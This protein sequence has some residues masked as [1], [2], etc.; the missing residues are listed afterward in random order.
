MTLNI[1]DVLA[2]ASLP[3]ATVPLCLAGGLVGEFEALEHD[4]RN[5][6]TKAESLGGP[7]P[8]TAIAR[9]MEDLRETMKAAEVAFKLTALPPPRWKKEI[10]AVQPPDPTNDEERAAFDDLWH[11]WIC[12][13]VSMIVTEPAM[14]PEQ[15]DELCQKLSSSQWTL[16]TNSVWELNAQRRNVPFSALASALTHS[17]ETSST[18]PERGASRT[19]SSSAKSPG[20]SPRTPTT[21]TGA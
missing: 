7:A 9:Q 18:R 5:A 16:L 19:R 14:T 3:T 8:A 12:F 15:A 10:M 4:L 21:T 13:M 1:D 17:S 2:Q 20:R 11:A 6:S